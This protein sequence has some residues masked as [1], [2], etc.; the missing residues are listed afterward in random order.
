[1]RKL[2]V[3]KCVILS[4]DR[5]RW[6]YVIVLRYVILLAVY[7]CY[8][9]NHFTG[10]VRRTP[11][12]VMLTLHEKMSIPT[13]APNNEVRLTTIYRNFQLDLYIF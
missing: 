2:N 7:Q 1:M 9:N 13:K 6:A 5:Y 11:P 4:V 12:K 8:V 10:N 3:W